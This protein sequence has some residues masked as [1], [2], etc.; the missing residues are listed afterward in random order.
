MCGSIYYLSLVIPIF[1]LPNFDSE[2]S[3]S[4]KGVF[5][6]MIISF[7]AFLFVGGFWCFHTYLVFTNQTT[8]EYYLNQRL[9]RKAERKGKIYI[10]PF[11]FGWKENFRLTFGCEIFSFRWLLP[12]FAP[13]G[14]G[15][16]YPMKEQPTVE[17]RSTDSQNIQLKEF[18]S[19]KSKNENEEKLAE[20]ESE[21]LIDIKDRSQ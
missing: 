7:F 1:L 11:D 20:S 3:P 10:N 15:I 2:S 12:G 19:R 5:L 18:Y 8:I 9:T 13:I 21:T 16:H 14:D 4:S 6:T 17:D